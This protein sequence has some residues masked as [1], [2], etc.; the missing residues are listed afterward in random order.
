MNVLDQTNKPYTKKL[1]GGVSEL[2]NIEEE[3]VIDMFNDRAHRV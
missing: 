1:R 2:C 3:D